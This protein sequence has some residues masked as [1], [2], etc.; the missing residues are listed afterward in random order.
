VRAALFLVLGLAACGDAQTSAN[1]GEF[2]A[3]DADFLGFQSWQSFALPDSDPLS[4]VVYPAGSR[5]AFL[6]RAPPRGTNQY[7]MGT[8]VVKAIEVGAGPADWEVLA[9]AKRGGHYNPTGAKGWE[10]FLLRVGAD[11]GEAHIISRGIQ[12]DDDGRPPD[13]GLPTAAGGY[14]EGQG[15]TPCNVCHG[16]SRLADVDFM[17]GDQLAPAMTA[18]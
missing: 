9:M 18:R 13:G 14:F 4:D 16:Q 8:L 12:P 3:T 17:L 10:F 15:I 2:D 6:N 7:P 1:T 11:D 5:V